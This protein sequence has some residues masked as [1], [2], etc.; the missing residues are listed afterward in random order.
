MQILKGYLHPFYLTDA[1]FQ[2]EAA[3]RETY[4]EMY[5]TVRNRKGLGGTGASVSYLKFKVDL[6]LNN[7]TLSM[8][9]L[10]FLLYHTKHSEATLGRTET[11]PILGRKDVAK[12]LYILCLL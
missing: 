1:N 2:T 10:I 9:V 12:T 4:W 6:N 11:G 7:M 8:N 3:I 5:S